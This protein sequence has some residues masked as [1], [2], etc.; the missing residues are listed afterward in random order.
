MDMTFLE[1]R[2]S[3]RA[4][5]RRRK[6]VAKQTHVPSF[7]DKCFVCGSLGKKGPIFGMSRQGLL[8]RTLYT[9]L[10]RE[11]GLGRGPGLIA[12]GRIIAAPV[13][14]GV[15]LLYAELLPLTIL[16]RLQVA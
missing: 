11:F 4:P 16:W 7:G 9:V 15:W 8:L 1:T 2:T 5:A 13:T 14:D 6:P 12:C 3:T 10:G